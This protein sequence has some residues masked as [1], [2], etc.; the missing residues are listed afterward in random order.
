MDNSKKEKRPSSPSIKNF[1]H[2]VGRVFKLDEL[3]RIVV[4]FPR[5]KMIHSC[6]KNNL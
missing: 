3:K 1:I 4:R 6:K 2:Q 5:I